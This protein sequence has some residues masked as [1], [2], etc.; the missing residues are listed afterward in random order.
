[1]NCRVPLVGFIAFKFKKSTVLRYRKSIVYNSWPKMIY[2]YRKL[3]VKKKAKWQSA[4]FY[5]HY[6]FLF[7]VFIFDSTIHY[8]VSE[9]SNTGLEVPVQTLYLKILKSPSF[10]LEYSVLPTQVTVAF[11]YFSTGFL[12]NNE[13]YMDCCITIGLSTELIIK[14]TLYSY[15]YLNISC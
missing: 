10:L 6:R 5:R 13:P 11:W 9:I 2:S 15:I 1:M 4:N 3:H 12:Q 7:F 8:D 14:C